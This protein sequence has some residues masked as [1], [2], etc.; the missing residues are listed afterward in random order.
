MAPWEVVKMWSTHGNI[1]PD[2]KT[3]MALLESSFG[4]FMDLKAGCLARADRAD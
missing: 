1:Q 2:A 3:E 4:I